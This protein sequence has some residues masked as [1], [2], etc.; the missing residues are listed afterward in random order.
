MSHHV[1][2]CIDQ[3]DHRTRGGFSDAK[4]YTQRRVAVSAFC[5]YSRSHQLS[6][7]DTAID[8]K[9]AFIPPADSHTTPWKGGG[10]C[11]LCGSALLGGAMDSNDTLVGQSKPYAG[12]DFTTFHG[13]VGEATEVGAS[14]SLAFLTFHTP[15]TA[16]TR[17]HVFRTRFAP[18]PCLTRYGNVC[19]LSPEDLAALSSIHLRT[20]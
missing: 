13:R 6:R 18:R 19:T 8:I 14:C 7:I 2:H 1:S 20:R 4:L 11:T 16:T 17:S 5:G 15:P 12:C 3:D 9:R 10:V